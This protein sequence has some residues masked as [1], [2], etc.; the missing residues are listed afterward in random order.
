MSKDVKELYEERLGRYQAAMALEPVDRI[1]I[2]IGSNNFAESYTASNQE[3]IY[4]PQKWLQSE[5]DFIRDFPEFDVLRNNRFWG[6]MYDALGVKTYKF[7]GRDLA[8]HVATQF[9]ESE[10]MLADDYDALI[11][12]PAEFMLERFLPRVLGEMDKS[13][14][15]SHFAF[16]KAGLAQGTF[17]EIMRNRSIQLQNQCGMPQPMTG[18]FVAPFDALGDVLR[19]LTGV[20]RDIR[21]QPDKVLEAC[22][23]LAP[24]MARFALSTADPLRRYPIFV[25]THKPTFISPKQFDTFYWPSFKKTLEM[26][27]ASGH[28]VRIYMEGDWSKHWHHVLE[29]PKGSVICDIDDQADIFQAKADIGH[30]VCIAGGILSRMFILGT[31]EEI[32]ARVKLLCEKAGAGGGYMMGGG[33]YLPGNSKPQNVRAMVDAVM[34][35]G[36][37]DKNIKARPLPP[38]PVSSQIPG[39][40]A[41]QVL[42]PWSVKK[43]E[44]G[45][46]L[47]DEELIQKPWETIEGM[48]FNWLWSW[49]M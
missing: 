27:I 37:Y 28:K 29:L 40:S 26:I 3:V 13:S 16:L 32:D 30:H 45:G 49:A 21:R 17:A 47:G 7:P 4:N 2:A 46:V 1:P 9:V 36:W 43:A 20:L 38:L 11:A 8:P 41:Q 25:P 44:M 31:P 14:T 48:A 19:G 42:T 24:I 33:C 12:N 18:A 5:M 23:V 15:R 6:P 34:K 39:L 35:Y 10:Y 22:E